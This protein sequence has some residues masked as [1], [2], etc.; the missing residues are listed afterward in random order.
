MIAALSF[1]TLLASNAGSAQAEAVAS[2]T[3]VAFIAG[4]IIAVMAL[5]SSLFV[6]RVEEDIKENT[7]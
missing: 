4:G 3:R 5:V 7:K 2:G 6:T 1:G